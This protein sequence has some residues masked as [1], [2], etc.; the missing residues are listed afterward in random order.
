MQ[1]DTPIGKAFRL[2]GSQPKALKRLGINTV[3]DLLFHFPSRYTT[4]ED[5]KFVEELEVGDH[6]I[7]YGTI[8]KLEAKK[9]W[10]KK[11][12]MAEG[13]FSDDTGTIQ[14][15]WFNQPYIAKM[16]HSGTLVKL[17]GKVQERKEKLYISNPEFEKVAGVP[18]KVGDSL[19]G[20]S[21]EEWSFPVYPETSGI[22]SKWMWHAIKK[23][24]SKGILDELEDPLP[25]K[26]REEYNLPPLKTSLIWIHTP[27]KMRDAET[28]RKRFS[29]E[30]IF[31]IQLSKQ[32]SRRALEEDGAEVISDAKESMNEFETFLPFSFTSAQRKVVD[33]IIEDISTPPAMSRLVEGDVGS[34][35]TAVAAATAYA[36]AHAGFQCAYMAPTSILANQHALSFA[37]YFKDT[38]ISIALLTASTANVYT[39]TH[40]EMEK[41]ALIEYV[42]Q[43]RVDILI[44]T[45]ALIQKHVKF[46]NLALALIDEQHRFGV[47]QRKK[48]AGKGEL[49]HLLSLTATPIPR[50]LAL[51]LYG[52]LDI[53]VINE[54]PPGRKYPETHLVL[55]SKR[56]GV[57]EAVRKE[58]EEGRQLYVI[59][60]RINEPDPRKET[61][62]YMKSV[63]AETERLQKKVF[64]KYTIEMLHGRMKSEEKDE[65]MKRFSN[66]EI[67][68]LV[69]TSVI[70]VGVS[71]ANAT[72]IIIEGAERFGLAQLHQLRGRVMRSTHQPH[73]Y[74][75]T[76]SDSEHT[77][78]RLKALQKSANGFELAEQD[79]L[80]RGP[81]ELS[82]LRQSGISDVAM[83]ALKNLKMVEA[84][85]TEARRIIESDPN[86]E[87]HP[88]LQKH[89]ET[90]VKEVHFE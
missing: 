16:L 17:E 2:T 40:L 69:S 65:I 81:G 61:A 72:Q 30:E 57:Y 60:P 7:L 59:C 90:Y 74:L 80:E 76:N 82:G 5:I 33:E 86:L 58:L 89:L 45:H 22:T 53:S 63:E 21:G 55:P 44:G 25:E 66:G 6:A 36:A 1:P 84:A 28:A 75:F 32:Q 23:A 37:E 41:E 43:G 14:V 54:L 51:T 19:W 85:R 35:K 67:D 11:M 42:E 10:R 83:E 4:V 38:G 79:L 77:L 18:Q 87:D 26:L 50:T 47:R 68:I 39:P 20:E 70:E 46:K 73:C 24:F 78:R 13:R 27:E 64:S 31:Y 62:L 15:V 9:T 8:E 88:Q 3:R 48:L 49:P 29:F 52:D 34:G 12:T 71:V 56:E